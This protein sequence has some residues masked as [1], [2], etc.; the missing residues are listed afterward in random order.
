M[1]KHVNFVKAICLAA[2]GCLLVAA[3]G[4]G[5]LAAPVDFRDDLGQQVIF[6][7]PPRRVVSLVPSVT[8]VIFALGEGDRVAAVT[9]ADTWPP[10]ATAL[11]PSQEHIL[12][13]AR[14]APSPAVFEKIGNYLESAR[15]LGQRTAELHVLLGAAPDDPVFAPEPFS[16]LYQRALYQS[17]RTLAKQVFGLLRR[18]IIS[19]PESMRPDAAEVLDQQPQI[20]AVFERILRKK[21]WKLV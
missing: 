13:L 15:L 7:G 11:L 17:M 10:E 6:T 18:R 5:L 14:E 21:K 12:D 19:L 8:E 20:L 3:S 9:H 4:P 2:L 1:L 16:K